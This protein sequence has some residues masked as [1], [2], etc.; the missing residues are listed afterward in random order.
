LKFTGPS[1]T[2]LL[3]FISDNRSVPLSVIKYSI[4]SL[5]AGYITFWIVK[6]CSNKENIF[7]EKKRF[8]AFTQKRYFLFF[9]QSKSV[10]NCQERTEMYKTKKEGINSR[11]LDYIIKTRSESLCASPSCR[12]ADLSK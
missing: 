2:P 7:K 11:Y 5:H 12:H 6:N 9:E 4:F 3:I 10:K 1:E 8:I